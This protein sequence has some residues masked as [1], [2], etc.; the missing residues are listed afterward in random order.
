MSNTITLKKSGVS[1]NAPS[2]SDLSLGEIALNY[3]DGHLYYKSGASA[4]PAKI[5]AKDADTLDGLHA[6]SFIKTSGDGTISGSLTIDDITINGSNISDA[7]DL[8]IDVGGDL[9]LDA[10]GGDIILEDGGTIVGTL[11]MNQSG[12]NFEVRSRVSDKDLVFKG[13]DGGTEI[14]ALTLDMSNGGSAS[15]RDDVDIGNNL[16]LISASS[17]TIQVK[18]T[19]NN[20]KLLIYSQ[21]GDSI[22][23]TY[24][25]HPLKFFTNS[26][27]RIT[28]AAGGDTTF[29]GTVTATSFHGDGSNLTGL[30]SS[31]DNTKLPKA[32]GNMTGAITFSGTGNGYYIGASGGAS[33][34]TNELR[35]GSTTTSN[36]IGLELYHATNPVTLGVGYS[37][38]GALAFIESAHDSYDVNTHLL[39]KPGGSETW[40]IGSHGTGGTYSNS[41]EIKPAAAGNDFYISNNSGTPILY[42]DTS[43]S[44]IG[45][46][47]TSPSRGNLVVKGDFQTIA[48]GNGQVA[49][50]SKVSGS[51]EAAKDVGGQIV[52]GGPISASDSNRT[53]GLV[54][55]YKENNTSGDRAGYLTFGT[56]QNAGS[57]DIFER[58]RIDSIGNVGIGITG[59]QSKLH[60]SAGD[61]RI[62]NNQE[63]LAETAAGGTIGVAKMDGSD[64]LLIGDGNLKIDVTG[65]SPR[66]TI[67]SSGNAT[68]AGDIIVDTPAGNSQTSHALKLK[69]TNSGGSV[70]VGAEITASPYASN[71]NGGNL[72]FKTANTS[73]SATT[74]LTLDGAQNATFAGNVTVPAGSAASPALTFSTDTDT[75]LFNRTSGELNFAVGGNWIAAVKPTGLQVYAGTGIFNRL[76]S[77]AA[78]SYTFNDDSDTG[79]YRFTSGSN[80]HLGISTGGVLRGHF[81]PAGIQSSGN[82]YTANTSEFRNFG[83]TW[84]A[85]TGVTG[86]GF[87]FINS[88]DG[89]AMT[90]SSSGDMV[91]NGSV[92]AENLSLTSLSAQN[93]EATALMISGSN[94]VGTRELGSNAFTSTSFAPL[95]SPALTGSPTA[96]T[97]DSSE[98]STKIAT[99]AYVKSQ[100]YITTDNNTFRTVK[101]GNN[102]L[103]ATETL[104]FTAGSNVTI[105]ESGGEVT[106]ASTDTNTEY[107]AGTH[108]ALSGTT[109]NVDF[110]TTDKVVNIGHNATTNNEG[111]IILDT[112]IAGSPQIGFTEHGDASWAIGVDDNDN[113]FKISGVA[114]ATIPTINN[115]TTPDFE[116]DINGVAYSAGNRIFAD[117]YHPNADA[118]TTARTISLGSD[119]TGSASFNGSSNITINAQI[120]ANAVG[121]SEIAADA[122]GASEIAASAVGASELNVSG[123][124][125]TTQFLRSDGDGSFTW[126]TPP[127]TQLSSA[128]V[129]TALSGTGLIS[130]NSSTGVISTTANNYS[131]PTH[132]GDDINIDTGALTG[133]TVISDLDFNITTDTEGH[134]TDANGTV[135]TRTLTAANLGIAKPNAPATASATI[136]GETIEVTFTASTTSNIDAYLIYSSIDGSDYGLISVVPPDDFSSTMSIIDNAFDE[137]G[138]QAYRVY[139]MKH[140]ILSDKKDASVSYAVSSLEPTNMS[141]VNLNN[142]FYIQWDQPSTN[143]RFVSVYNVYKH[144]H[145]TQGSLSR[146]SASLVYSGRNTSYMYQISGTN[147]TNFHQ[148][149]VEITI[150]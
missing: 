117:N 119:L 46:G 22:I 1:G 58:M 52:F 48:S 73:A 45:I 31:T 82:V 30:P 85:T 5:N 23:G 7:G 129:R 80:D 113:S 93:S 42:S 123:N 24:S 99:T 121:A 26:T 145:A 39:F 150:S 56:R 35:I 114:S 43:T 112:S 83:G 14:T 141:V 12:G 67:D 59:P 116:I 89:T 130:Y 78:P 137:T 74:A 120:A 147:N 102:T 11:S 60:V 50:I 138:T 81:G 10:D 110:A 25:N 15:F 92:T 3:A 149:W 6:S 140:G 34:P 143:A 118:L 146:N 68:F 79:I 132:P 127:N 109:F 124:G 134:V 65:T 77:A 98:N 95:A 122:V 106:I 53:F 76:G 84:K 96:P 20:C 111:E 55:G 21:D 37:G 44:K 70:Q 51:N 86:N 36:N 105:T 91:V 88:V 66:L 13:N 136:V 57:R 108:L 148:F 33:A 126:A 104:E 62:D 69:K 41:F 8:Y 94:V 71:T 54:G 75:G 103:G 2:S 38:G 133:A 142:A 27:E 97:Q 144:E 19:T 100:G 64:N 49:V 125:S 32:G 17:P 40:R 4:T 9:H 16:N 90:L 28:I 72:V 135:S 131:H 47:T 128:E 107:T 61:I 63:Y 87:Q 18:D 139:A 115:L 29:T 101:A